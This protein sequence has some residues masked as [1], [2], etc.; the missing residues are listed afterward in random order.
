MRTTARNGGQP[1]PE[2]STAEI[3]EKCSLGACPGT[4]RPDPAVSQTPEVTFHNQLDGG[5]L[6]LGEG[7]EGGE[8]GGGGGGA[9]L[10]VLLLLVVAAAVG[11]AFFYQRKRGRA[12]SLPVMSRTGF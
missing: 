8:G 11:S 7:G 3:T 9:A 5:R 12:I 1:C 4:T 10:P 2:L 6:G